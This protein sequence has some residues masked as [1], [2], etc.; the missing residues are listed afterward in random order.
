[1]FF[2]SVFYLLRVIRVLAD[3]LCLLY[4]NSRVERCHILF[5]CSAVAGHLGLFLVWGSHSVGTSILGSV[6]QYMSDFLR[7]FT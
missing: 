5:L 6:S 2:C 1:M 4:S 7:M 3:S